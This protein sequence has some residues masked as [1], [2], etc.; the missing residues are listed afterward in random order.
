MSGWELV[1]K[2]EEIVMDG[3]S[4][5]TYR[6]KVPGGWIYKVNSSFNYLG[7]YQ[8]GNESLCF[9]PVEQSNGEYKN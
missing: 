9:V 4:I 2:P 6:M 8:G 3:E 7:C 5:Y 1:D